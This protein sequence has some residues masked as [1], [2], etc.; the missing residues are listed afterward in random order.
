MQK[1][2]GMAGASD[3]DEEA[4]AFAGQGKAARVPAKCVPSGMRPEMNFSRAHVPQRTLNRIGKDAPRTF[5][6]RVF[7]NGGCAQRSLAAQH[8]GRYIPRR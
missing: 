1:G 8:L 5:P 4:S 3:E 6:G 7:P 2:N